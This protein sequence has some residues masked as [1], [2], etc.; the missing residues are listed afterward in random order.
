MTAT[1]QSNGKLKGPQIL[2]AIAAGTPV[3]RVERI[4]I[5]PLQ[6]QRVTLNIR[7]TSP[8]ITHRFSEKAKK[9]MRD[10]TQMKAKQKKDA[11]DPV[12]EFLDA[13]YFISRNP[14]RY[15]VSA[16]GFYAAALD[17]ALAMDA[18]KSEMR[19]AFTVQPDAFTADG[20][21]VEVHTP[22]PPVM[23]EDPVKVGMTTMLRYRPEFREWS[24]KLRVVFDARQVSAE[25]I[26]NVFNQAGFSTGIAEWRQQ[27]E[28]IYGSFEVVG[29]E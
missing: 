14:D 26:V 11:Q 28:G 22:E 24:C 6:L 27:K 9:Q 15:G 18:K 1:I 29:L 21:L 8:L 20:P 25:Q 10:K 16:L 2:E 5:K 23:R 17:A 3:E 19:R 7:G 12:Q 4:D 13:T